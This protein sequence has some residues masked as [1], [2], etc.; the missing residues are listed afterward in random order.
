M[1][2]KPKKGILML[3]QSACCTPKK[4]AFLV[5]HMYGPV[6]RPEDD[7]MKLCYVVFRV[8]ELKLDRDGQSA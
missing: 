3:N 7:R 1:T 2:A 8:S 6:F 5:R 4:G